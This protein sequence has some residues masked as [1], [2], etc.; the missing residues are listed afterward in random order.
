MPDKLRLE[1]KDLITIGTIIVSLTTFFLAM[2]K[3]LSLYEQKLDSVTRIAET[4]QKLAMDH[5]KRIIIL[6]TK[7]K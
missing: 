3:R 7:T 6:E 4:V 5:E 2:D 1:L